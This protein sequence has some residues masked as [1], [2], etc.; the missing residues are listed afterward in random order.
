MELKKHLHKNEEINSQENI[1]HQ[2]FLV[3]KAIKEIKKENIQNWNGGKYKNK[4]KRKWLRKK[5]IYLNWGQPRK[6]MG[7]VPSLN[8]RDV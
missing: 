2:F 7:Q 5:M 3:E 4:R 8:Y 6:I 1:F